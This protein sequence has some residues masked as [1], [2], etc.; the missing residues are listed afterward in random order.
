MSKI[1]NSDYKLPQLSVS[2]TLADTGVYDSDLSQSLH[3]TATDRLLSK[4]E[5]A[6]VVGKIGHD[7]RDV[8][9]DSAYVQEADPYNQANQ[10]QV[11]AQAQLGTENKFLSFKDFMSRLEHLGV[12]TRKAK[13]WGKVEAFNYLPPINLDKFAN[14]TDYNWCPPNPSIAP[15]YITIA[16][17]S[18]QVD[19]KTIHL[20]SRSAD[21]VG[22]LAPTVAFD[23]MVWLNTVTSQL[24]RYSGGTWHITASLDYTIA[25][26]VVATSTITVVGDLT[27]R[28]RETSSIYIEAESPYPASFATVIEIAYDQATDK[29]TMVLE[30][31]PRPGELRNRT[32][33]IDPILQVVLRERDNYSDPLLDGLVTRP[34]TNFT[35]GDLPSIIWAKYASV[36]ATSDGETVL[37]SNVLTDPGYQFARFVDKGVRNDDAVHI[38]AGRNRGLFPIDTIVGDLA[39]ALRIP[40]DH[41]TMFTE[42]SFDYAVIRERPLFSITGR[43]PPTNPIEGDYWVDTEF[44]ILRQFTS[45]AFV[46]VDSCPDLDAIWV[47]VIYNFSFLTHQLGTRY[48]SNRTAAANP[49]SQANYWRHRSVVTALGLTGT[50][51]A[52]LPIIEFNDGLELAEWRRTSHKWAY[53]STLQDTFKATANKP[54]QNELRPYDL[55]YPETLSRLSIAGAFG[56]RTAEF[57]EGKQFRIV[58]SLGGQLDGTYTVASSTFVRYSQTEFR[59]RIEL[60]SDSQ[61]RAVFTQPGGKLIPLTTSTGDPWT[62]YQNHWRYDGVDT[63]SLT[64]PHQLSVYQTAFDNVIQTGI[65]GDFEYKAALGFQEWVATTATTAQVFDLIAQLHERAR[66]SSTT[67]NTVVYVNGER[68]TAYDDAVIGSHVSGVRF[69]APLQ[70]EIGDVI[71]VELGPIVNSDIGLSSVYTLLSDGTTAFVDLSEYRSIPQL[72]VE[73]NQYP[74]F[75]LYDASYGPVDRASTLFEYAVDEAEGEFNMWI[76]RSLKVV[77]NEYAFNMTANGADGTI[78]AFKDLALNYTEQA[79]SSARSIWY[80]NPSAPEFAVPK[81]VDRCGTPACIL[82]NLGDPNAD[83]DW[84]VPEYWT[85]NI[86]NETA[87]TIPTSALVTHFRSIIASQTVGPIEEREVFFINSAAN[88]GAGGTIKMYNYGVDITASSLLLETT[89]PVAIIE[90]GHDTYVQQLE[91]LKELSRDVIA[92]TFGLA[93]ATSLSAYVTQ[94]VSRT[95]ARFES[96]DELNR[97]FGDSYNSAAVRNFVDTLP[98]LG[99]VRY[100][101]P[102]LL[103]DT[104]RGITKLL[105]HD[106]HVSTFEFNVAQARRFLINLIKTRVPLIPS[107]TYGDG[108]IEDFIDGID[109]RNGA[110]I[111]IN[112]VGE[113]TGLYFYIGVD[114][115]YVAYVPTTL[116]ILNTQRTAVPETLNVFETTSGLWSVVDTHSV[117]ETIEQQLLLTV[118]RRLYDLQHAALVQYNLNSVVPDSNYAAL[119]QRRYERYVEL[120]NITNASRSTYSSTDPFTWNYTGALAST[121]PQLTSPVTRGSWQG[122]YQF[123]YNTPY[124]HLE[125]WKLQKYV[126]KPDWWDTV[127]A[128]DTRRW[129][130]EMWF[131]IVFGIIPIG[132]VGP[133]GTTVSSSLDNQLV[134]GYSYVPVNTQDADLVINDSII[135]VEQTFESDALLP[136]YV[137]MTGVTF[138]SWVRS[139]Y[140]KNAL[141]GLPE[142]SFPNQ[143]SDYVFGTYGP[144][145]AEWRAS[146]YFGYDRAVIAWQVDPI[147]FTYLTQGFPTTTVGRLLVDA[148]RSIVHSHS[149]QQFHGDYVAATTDIYRSGGINQWYVNYH[150]QIR[151]DVTEGEFRR[152][153]TAWAPHLAYLFNRAVVPDSVRITSPVA[154]IVEGDYSI[155]I[156]N[157][158]VLDVLEHSGLH[159]RVIAAPSKFSPNRAN[160]KEWEFEVESTSPYSSQMTIVDVENYIT[161]PGVTDPY[162]WYVNQFSIVNAARYTTRTYQIA[163]FAGG[164][165]NYNYLTNIN[166]TPTA[167]RTLTV[168]YSDGVT[169]EA[170]VVSIST[171]DGRV[172]TIGGLLTMINE[173]LVDDNGT[174]IATMSIRNGNLALYSY[175]RNVVGR[176]TITDDDLLY[177]LA[178]ADPTTGSTFGSFVSIDSAVTGD[179][180][181]QTILSLDGNR[182]LTVEAGD[183]VILEGTGGDGSYVVSSVNYDVLTETTQ[184]SFDYE[185]PLTL[186]ATGTVTRPASI[187]WIVGDEVYFTSVGTLPSPLSETL[188]VYVAGTTVFPGTALVKSLIL[189]PSPEK[190]KQ[191][192]GFLTSGVQAATLTSTYIIRA[193][194]R[195]DAEARIGKLVS[196]FKAL[197]GD[198][199]AAYWRRHKL[200]DLQRSYTGVLKIT[201][202]QA[203]IDFIHGYEAA[204][205]AAGFVF[206]QAADSITDDATGR[207]NDWQLHLEKFIVILHKQ[208]FTTIEKENS[209]EVR[210]L[211]ADTLTF[212]D[213]RPMSWSVTTPIKLTR[214]DG[215]LPA[216][217]GD[218]TA[219]RPTVFYA[220]GD[221]ARK[222]AFKLAYTSHDAAAGRFITFDVPMYQSGT[223]TAPH[224]ETISIATTRVLV[225]HNKSETDLSKLATTVTV[226]GGAQPTRVIASSTNALTFE[227]ATAVTGT[228]TVRYAPTVYPEHTATLV[229]PPLADIDSDYAISEFT[230]EHN[231]NIGDI[232]RLLVTYHTTTVAGSDPVVASRVSAVDNNSIRVRFDVPVEGTVVISIMPSVRLLS[233]K[234][235]AKALQFV[236][237]FESTINPYAA[238]CWIETPRGIIRD[239]FENPTYA[240]ALRSSLYDSAGDSLSAKDLI[241]TRFDMLTK[242]NLRAAT[243]RSIAGMRVVTSG[244]EHVLIFNDI[245]V[246]GSTIYDAKL[247][248]PNPVYYIEFEGQ[249]EQNFRMNLGGYF[250]SDNDIVRNIEGQAEDLRYAYD[251]YKAVEGSAI[252]AQARASIGYEGRVDFLADNNVNNRSQFL[253]WKAMINHKGTKV[254]LTA[255]LRGVD[256]QDIIIDEFWAY[257]VAEFGDAKEQTYPEMKLLVGD[258]DQREFR[259]EFLLPQDVVTGDDFEGIRLTDTSRW[260]NQPD[261]VATY[262][263]KAFF[264]NSSVIDIDTNPQWTVTNDQFAYY[265]TTVECDGILLL[266]TKSDGVVE[267]YHVGGDVDRLNART[268]RVKIELDDTD[269]YNEI[270]IAL[271]GYSTDAQNTAVLLDSESKTLVDKVTLWDPARG[272]WDLIGHQGIDIEAASDPAKYIVTQDLEGTVYAVADTNGWA[273]NKIGTQWLDTSAVRHIPYYD[274]QVFPSIDDR[275]RLWGALEPWSR[276]RV[277]EWTESDVEPSAWNAQVAKSQTLQPNVLFPKSGTPLAVLMQRTTSGWKV[278]THHHEVHTAFSLLTNLVAGSQSIAGVVSEIG[279]LGAITI[280]PLPGAL[281]LDEWTF[282]GSITFG[283]SDT[284]AADHISDWT[285]QLTLNTD[286]A[287][288]DVVSVGVTT[289]VPEPLSLGFNDEDSIDV[290]VNGDYEMTVA[291]PL[292]YDRLFNVERPAEFVNAYITLVRPVPTPTPNQLGQGTLKYVYPYT[293]RTVQDQLTGE[294][295][296]LYYFWVENRTTTNSKTVNIT[297]LQ[298]RQLLTKTERPYMIWQDLRTEEEGFGVIWGNVFDQFEYGLPG[299]YRQMIVRG[300]EGHVTQDNRYSLRFTRD[301]TLRDKL[302]AGLSRKTVHT[303]WKMFREAQTYKIDSTLWNAIAEAIVGYKLTDEAILVPALNRVLYDSLN[304]TDTRFG[305]G[306]GQAFVDQALALST[307]QFHIANEN[308]PFEGF[309]GVE[310]L[311]RYDLADAAALV[312]F[313]EDIYVGCTVDQVNFLFFDVLMDAFATKAQ[314]REIFKTSWVSLQIVRDLTPQIQIATITTDP[315]GCIEVPTTTTTTRAPAPIDDVDVVGCASFTTTTTAAPIVYAIL[316]GAGMSASQGALLVETTSTGVP[317]I[318]YGMFDGFN[319]LYTDPP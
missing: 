85:T 15:E 219:A 21:F 284:R 293:S 268:Y 252:T 236:P 299:R 132:K 133:N 257:K 99:L 52:Q 182:S 110:V 218:T 103:T 288:G 171:T 185:M 205:N 116:T 204:G 256:V 174:Q 255:F 98:V 142:T 271:I 33:F 173:Q 194:N 112:L 93:S 176:V 305:L 41:A 263:H 114:G 59:T 295:R 281:L 239:V 71:R 222:G 267:T 309:G 145:E 150:R 32:I 128:G 313:M 129:S 282:S 20:L 241:L 192:A 161:T 131:N 240:G 195:G 126:T 51:Q 200:A 259:A 163:N 64:S 228:I 224:V 37:G 314:Y 232:G 262:P 223:D 296:S 269:F 191:V 11:V 229:Q 47:P 235:Y 100:V 158:D 233:G 74:L 279:S 302:G 304:G 24:N 292:L 105:H 123:Y 179:A 151:H 127:Y 79:I 291:V 246:D 162:N 31:V 211:D 201:G 260:V 160:G 280:A 97:T 30:G 254:P 136:P 154:E 8:P 266:R 289:I 50:K 253:F 290:Y 225:V 119:S 248:I 306:L 156:K 215:S 311:N 130:E 120:E 88:L 152:L 25:D 319:L 95:I 60:K 83:G 39:L 261:L 312:Q 159:V 186:I 149:N 197:G 55:Y 143:M 16:N 170:I 34:T 274:E 153:W 102:Q 10:L 203:L 36:A 6:R 3:G 199:V 76:Q 181:E 189:A 188:P 77:D 65:I 258:A 46:D 90:F 67:N 301:F 245:A 210:F 243:N 164:W 317:P 19:D 23:G 70:L 276:V 69:L 57:T 275:T 147:R 139:L 66:Y 43:T 108:P 198:I 251:P 227:F 226:T 220:V 18:L 9:C 137:D 187:D 12:D 73:R 113:T 264:L 96:N 89:D 94:V 283:A 106:G 307:I 122:L 172:A 155:A 244:Q 84:A 29:T 286:L 104:A 221:K 167:T 68:V 193:T 169:S 45:A 287:V 294:R 184:L 49:W 5:L 202:V 168:A 250:V 17:S 117:L 61:L 48:I 217:I 82:N 28:V 75:T 92:D 53:R 209:Y 146:S 242:I 40:N 308:G 207:V 315:E 63:V 38:P 4:T 190:A 183:T 177:R 297:T 298:A 249:A 212:T 78:Y 166:R 141:T 247:G 318:D 87:T 231:L 58:E 109:V 14:Y 180:F 272:N 206:R 316:T 208:S 230:I 101:E 277:Y 125:P 22:A 213:A 234:M 62:G 265:N 273:E 91:Q 86:I 148:D 72:K 165:R 13:Q 124:P 270:T 135:G 140:A 285:F 121:Y 238:G 157:T 54:D 35:Y 1:K 310:F 115:E 107:Y 7:T 175:N 27:T 44:D 118:E 196:T 237:A 138:P 303:E 278:V 111:A 2:N 134:A 81:F 144:V 300:L 216:I 178:P 214:T 56:D 80:S 42:T 26:V